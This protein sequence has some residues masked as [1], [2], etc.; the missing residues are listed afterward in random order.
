MADIARLDHVGDSA[1]GFFDRNGGVEAGGPVDVDIVELQSLQAVGEGG[2]HRRRAT[3]EPDPGPGRLALGPELDA[4]KVAVARDA[5]QGLAEQHFVV[6]HSI[7][8]ARIDEVHAC[9]QRSVDGGDAFGPIR[10]PVHARHPHTAEA[11]GKN[12]GVVQT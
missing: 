7:E 4:D 8:V 5:A 11:Q 9:F 1:D 6:T 3:V 12:A 10:R 2:L